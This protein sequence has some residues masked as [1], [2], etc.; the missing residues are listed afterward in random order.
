MPS[1]IVLL[2]PAALAG[3]FADAL[4]AGGADATVTPVAT[5]EA[6]A[7]ACTDRAGRF[8]LVAFATDVIVP[9]SVL[10]ALGGPAYNLH[11]G[12][13]EYPGL[14]PSCFA[15]FEGAARFGSTLH[16]MTERVDDGTIVGADTFD[17]PAGVDRLT[18][19]ALAL[20]SAM[21]LVAHL[22]AELADVATPLRPLPLA[23]SGPRRTARD[24][25][26][27]CEIPPDISADDFAHRY[28]AVGEGPD[29]ALTIVLH[30]RRFRLAP[31][32]GDDATVYVAGQARGA[33]AG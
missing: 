15:L 25:A 6:L 2:S 20:A 10:G 29:H 30:G 23:W 27:L 4:G 1:E 16:E 7:A 5:L 3:R 22:A 11:P 8:R 21:R 13:P 32:G 18:L 17:M 14:F 19:D 9:A 24:F 26:R 28:R 33:T 31:E 12:P